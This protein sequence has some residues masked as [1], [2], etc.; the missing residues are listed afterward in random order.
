MFEIIEE[1]LR[2]CEKCSEYSAARQHSYPDAEATFFI[3]DVGPGCLGNRVIYGETGYHMIPGNMKFEC[4]GYYVDGVL[5]GSDTDVLRRPKGGPCYNREGSDEEAEAYFE[6]KFKASLKDAYKA[7][8]SQILDEVRNLLNKRPV[9]KDLTSVKGVEELGEKIAWD[10]AYTG[11]SKQTSG[12]LDRFELNRDDFEKIFLSLDND[13]TVQAIAEEFYFKWE[14]ELYVEKLA[15][16][17]SMTLDYTNDPQVIMYKALA[18]TGAKT[19]NC[20]INGNGKWKW[21]KIDAKGLLRCIRN[22]DYINWQFAT[23]KE[24]DE[25]V[26]LF[27][28]DERHNIYVNQIDS[29]TYGKKVIWGSTDI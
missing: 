26:D 28:E 23:Q 29:I 19:V 7:I 16:A 4:V 18:A 12:V 20:R 11:D 24:G 22:N 9:P 1:L 25:A 14:D 5:Y 6:G 21:Y 27:A 15:T 2:D 8:E 3:M 13:R 10:L 17:Y